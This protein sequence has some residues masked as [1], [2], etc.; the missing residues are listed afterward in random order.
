MIVKLI[1]KGRSGKFKYG[2]TYSTTWSVKGRGGSKSPGMWLF[3][4]NG[5]HKGYRITPYEFN[6]FWDYLD[7]SVIMILCLRELYN[8]S[9]DYMKDLVYSNN[10]FLS[11][12][13]RGDVFAGSYIPIPIVY[14]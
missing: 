8:D 4:L 9:K 13:P 10:P 7:H 2:K 14:S 6:K 3:K 11:M 12:M 5:W 1:Y